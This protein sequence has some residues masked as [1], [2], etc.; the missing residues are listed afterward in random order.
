MPVA[1]TIDVRTQEVMT[2]LQRIHPQF[3]YAAM[4]A[5]NRTAEDGL[6]ALR[7]EIPRRFTIREVRLLNLVAPRQLPRPYRAT[8]HHLAATVRT[9]GYARVFAPFET[10]TPKTPT[11][12]LGGPL[13]HTVIV[14]TGHLR[15]TRGT[16]IPRTLYPTSLGLAP[17]RDPKGTTYY[18]LGRGAITKKLTPVKGR[19]IVGK[20]GTFALIAGR[21]NIRPSQAGVY[22]RQGDT[23][24]MLWALEPMVRRPRILN[25]QTTVETVVA[26]RFRPN[27]EGAWELALRTAR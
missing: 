18:A 10:G 4:L 3:P 21:H 22:Q 11:S 12:R 13:A 19:S 23:V 24:R 9:D 1:L 2:F 26:E 27:W 7:S 5:L 6:A 25:Y 16:V 20:R 14:P 15:P 17:R 8:T